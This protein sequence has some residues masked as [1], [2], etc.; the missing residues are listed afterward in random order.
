MAQKEDETVPTVEIN[1]LSFTYPGIDGHPPPGSKPL[2]DDFSLTLNA[3]DRSLLV[4]SNG[5]GSFSYPRSK[6]RVISRFLL[7]YMDLD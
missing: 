5:A 6:G 2:I 7:S 4:G 3:G 1:G